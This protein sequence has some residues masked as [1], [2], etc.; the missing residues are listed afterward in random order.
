MQ[1]WKSKLFTKLKQQKQCISE[2]DKNLKIQLKQT[3]KN[4]VKKIKSTEFHR[5][6]EKVHV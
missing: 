5:S 3:L 1:H 2:N 6:A 4:T